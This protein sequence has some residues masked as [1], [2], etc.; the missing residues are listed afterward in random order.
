MSN[1]FVSRK[2]LII[3]NVNSGTTEKNVLVQDSNGLVKYR[4]SLDLDYLKANFIYLN[5]GLTSG[6]TFETGKIYY[7]EE[8]QTFAGMIDGD[9]ILQIGQESIAQVYNNNSYNILNG[10]LVYVT[11]SYGDALTVSLANSSI[12]SKS[13]VLGMATQ[14]ILSGHTGLVTTRGLVH[15]INTNAAVAGE[16]IYLSDTIDGAFVDNP[17]LLDVSS[18]MSKVGLVVR[19]GVTDGIIYVSVE[20]E[21]IN[22][23]LTTREQ[24]IAIGD[25]SST[26]VYEFAGLSAITGGTTFN[27]GAAKGWI[28]TNTDGSTT[29][30]DVKHIVFS[31]ITGATVTD[32]AN[33]YITYVLLNSNGDMYQQTTFPTCQQRRENI[34]LGKIAHIDKTVVTTVLSQPDQI[35][36]P[37][38]QLRDMFRPIPLIND[39]V[40]VQANGAN[41][42]INTSSGTLYGLGINF[43]NSDLSPDRI[44]VSAQIPATFRYRTQTGGTSADVTLIDPTN[45]DVG[46]IITP[47]PG[48]I[49]SKNATNQ[50][51]FL[52]QNGEIRVQYGQAVYPGVVEAVAAAQTESYIIFPGFK[53]DAILI[54]IICVERNCISLLDTTSSRILTVSKFGDVAGAAGGQSVTTLQIAY[55]NS[56]NPEIVT[57]STLGAVTLK[58]GISIESSNVLEVQSYGDGTV[59]SVNGS[60]LT[61]SNN[62]FNTE[63]NRS[64]VEHGYD[65]KLVT[66]VPYSERIKFKVNVTYSG[67]TI[68]A[69]VA[70]NSGYTSFSYYLLDRKYTV[71]G[72][73]INAYSGSSTALSEGVWFFYINNTTLNVANPVMILT[74]TPWSIYDPDVL[75]WNF[76]FNATDNTITWIGEERHTAGRDV[77]NHARNHAEGAIYKNGF[78]AS[79]YNGLTALSTDTTNNL[80]RA[81]VQIAGGSFYDE[82]ILNGIAHSDSAI[83][84]TT[85]NPF[86]D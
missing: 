54:G 18:R 62:F 59:F 26:G 85:S 50:R 46:G 68:R 14:N 39:G 71:S 69:S 24:N 65:T 43:T 1:E 83:T 10:Q 20:N 5:T 70:L 29:N 35:L 15:D 19:T 76:Y 60:G 12:D 16:I 27:V 49:G 2:G 48:G 25:V 40:Y 67:G 31:G 84:S 33:S 58:N 80:G 7:D 28:V 4:N 81:Q 57:N 41:L 78:L 75:L 11:G 63:L 8:H 32:I 55:D 77:F 56:T 47:V 21:N 9:V 30:P 74:R 17:L 82:D 61:T 72:S 3:H 34:F 23:S 44:L 45:Y 66:G 13:T 51:V 79:T 6:Q 37:V 52:L 38:S 42:N 22:L 36:S 53:T 86:T 64:E 73:T